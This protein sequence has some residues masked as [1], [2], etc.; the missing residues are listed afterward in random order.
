MKLHY[1]WNWVVLADLS[2]ALCLPMLLSSFSAF[3]SHP[4]LSCCHFPVSSLCKYFLHH[5]KSHPE[6]IIPFYFTDVCYRLFPNWWQ[7][8]LAFLTSNS[9]HCFIPS[10]LLHTSC[11]LVLM[12][13][14]S[15]TEEKW[16]WH[17]ERKDIFAILRR[18]SHINCLSRSKNDLF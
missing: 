17:I 11:I 12:Q 13:Q 9:F 14:M 2:D 16:P 3:H 15:E 7:A 5:L 6:E 18:G 10:I 1:E 8:F 4:L